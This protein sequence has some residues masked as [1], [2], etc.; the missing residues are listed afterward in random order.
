MIENKDS[1]TEDGSAVMS[2]E[3]TPRCVELFNV[4]GDE[5]VFLPYDPD[6]M[7]NELVDENEDDESVVV[8]VDTVVELIDERVP[9]EHSDQV[10]ELAVEGLEDEYTCSDLEVVLHV[11]DAHASVLWTKSQLSVEMPDE[12]SIGQSFKSERNPIKQT[13]IM[14]R[15]QASYAKE[16]VYKFGSRIKGLAGRSNTAKEYQTESQAETKRQTSK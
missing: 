5:W 11:M 9:V 4:M 6:E 10:I 13:F 2:V 8:S 15:E 12:V 14:V 1:N 7:L 16:T 3:N